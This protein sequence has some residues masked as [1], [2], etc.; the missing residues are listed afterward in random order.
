MS[1]M[2]WIE[3]LKPFKV[4]TEHLSGEKYPTISTLG[5]LLN[6]IEHKVEADPDDSAAIQYFK[7]ALKDDMKST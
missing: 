1:G 7:K 5:P 6:E 4:A 3:V 2:Y